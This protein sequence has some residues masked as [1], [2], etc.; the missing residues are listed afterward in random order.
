MQIT[1]NN[2]RE[3]VERNKKMSFSVI[4]WKVSHSNSELKGWLNELNIKKYYFW[5]FTYKVFNQN[6]NFL[7]FFVVSWIFSFKSEFSIQ[8]LNILLKSFNFEA[9][10]EF[11]TKIFF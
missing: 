6:S 2:N 8:N 11:L 5:I 3:E 1:F 10:L 9:K 7:N 4:L